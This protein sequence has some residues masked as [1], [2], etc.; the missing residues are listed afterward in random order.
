[1]DILHY[2]TKDSCLYTNLNPNPCR[3]FFL[4]GGSE[5]PDGKR[6]SF[7]L[8]IRLLQYRQRRAQKLA[9]RRH[10]LRI[11]EYFSVRADLLLY[12]R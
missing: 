12:R 10:V 11:S 9:R 4:P 2:T 8:I 7:N 3:G 5:Y 1:M 6:C